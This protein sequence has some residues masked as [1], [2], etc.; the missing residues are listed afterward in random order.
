M[1][2]SFAGDFGLSAR[3]ASVFV[4]WLI[5]DSLTVGEQGSVLALMSLIP[6]TYQTVVLSGDPFFKTAGM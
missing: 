6:A 3:A 4:P 2:S 1:L 5:R